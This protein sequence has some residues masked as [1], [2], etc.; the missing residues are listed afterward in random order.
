MGPDLKRCAGC[1]RALPLDS[2]HRHRGRKDGRQTY[3][4]DCKRGYGQDWYARNAAQHRQDT[5]RHRRARETRNR[6][7][8]ADLK[9]VPCADC[10][11]VLPPEAMDFD[12]VRGVKV[13]DVSRMTRRSREAILR[14]AAKCDVVC[15]T[16]HRIRTR[17]RGDA[18]PDGRRR[19]G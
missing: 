12:H 1:A 10:G 3:C 18:P 7:L 5:A 6:R 11:A 19:D 16:C 2:F 15:A 4:R 13:D 9:S 8:I 14:E 17:R